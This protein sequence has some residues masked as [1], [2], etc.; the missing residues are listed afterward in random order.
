ML[1]RDV[2]DGERKTCKA[3]N[4][5]LLVRGSL[6]WHSLDDELGTASVTY[7]NAMLKIDSRILMPKQSA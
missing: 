7:A 3:T 4:Q 6:F 5:N 1:C 2:V